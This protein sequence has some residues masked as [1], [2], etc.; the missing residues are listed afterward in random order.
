MSGIGGIVH[1]DDRPVEASGIQRMMQMVRHRGPDGHWH[2]VHGRVGLGFALLAMKK[3]DNQ[4]P[5][6]AWLPDASCGIVADVSLYNRGDII[7][8]LGEVPWWPDKPA[9]AEIILAAYERW[10]EDLLDMLDGDFAFAIWDKESGQIFAARDPF[11]AKP[12]FYYQDTNRFLF[13]SEPK[14]LLFMPGVPVVPDDERL[15]S[16]FSGTSKNWR[17]LFSKIFDA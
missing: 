2:E 9:D 14:Q 8:R 13:G 5:Q 3:S 15:E 4:H 10:R 16:F 12:L 6:P 11:G 17:E 7:R 1:W